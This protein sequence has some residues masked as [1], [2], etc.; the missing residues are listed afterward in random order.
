MENLITKTCPKQKSLPGIFC[1]LDS[2]ID[3]GQGINV[4]LGKIAKKVVVVFG[5]R[6]RFVLLTEFGCSQLAF[7]TCELK[8][9]I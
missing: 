1:T 4:G 5:R 7:R 9:K 8:W 6:S 2:R 3:I